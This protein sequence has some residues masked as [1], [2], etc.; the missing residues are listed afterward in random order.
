[1]ETPNKKFKINRIEFP[2][3]IA[4]IEHYMNEPPTRT[5]YLLIGIK[6][7]ELSYDEEDDDLPQDLPYFHGNIT[8]EVCCMFHNL[9]M[10]KNDKSDDND[11]HF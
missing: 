3:I 2:S 6:N 4:L 5:Y 11:K 1:M 8:K 9:A 7:P 10:D